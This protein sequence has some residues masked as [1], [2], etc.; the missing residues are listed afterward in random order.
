MCV[1]SVN[2]CV[3]L[4]FKMHPECRRKKRNKCNNSVN[5]ETEVLESFHFRQMRQ[6]FLL[7][8]AIL[9]FP[10]LYLHRNDIISKLKVIYNLAIIIISYSD[11][12]IIT[13]NVTSLN[14]CSRFI[15][16]TLIR[17]EKYVHVNV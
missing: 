16:N 17:V 13:I 7:M 15:T 10:F 8:Y 9:L 6:F 12:Y 3:L 11:F 4:F 1:C 5:P 14:R 2:S